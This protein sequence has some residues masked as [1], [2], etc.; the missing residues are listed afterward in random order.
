MLKN[1]FK[2][3]RER[4]TLLGVGTMSKN[5][6]DASIEISKKLDCPIMLI[7]SRSQ[8]DCAS[9]DGGYANKWTRENFADYVKKK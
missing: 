9:Q 6:V 8:I 1:I 7:A 5:C 3:I 2:S 4:K